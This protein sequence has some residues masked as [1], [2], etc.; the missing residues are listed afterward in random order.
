MR[1]YE[2]NR[3]NNRNNNNRGQKLYEPKQQYGQVQEQQRNLRSRELRRKQLAVQE[4]EFTRQN[5]KY[6]QVQFTTWFNQIS[7][8]VPTIHQII[9]KFQAYNNLEE[10]FTKMKIHSDQLN[11]YIYLMKIFGQ[12][13]QYDVQQYIDLI[14]S[15]QS[16]STQLNEKCTLLLLYQDSIDYMNQELDTIHQLFFNLKL[17]DYQAL[18][19][20][21]IANFLYVLKIIELYNPKLKNQVVQIIDNCDKHI[22]SIYSTNQI[23]LWRKTPIYPVE[24]EFFQQNDKPNQLF[25][26]LETLPSENISFDQYIDFHFNLLRQ[27]YI[28]ELKEAIIS[29]NESG[30]E[31]I[32]R[33][34]NNNVG[35][36]QNIELISAGMNNQDIVW[37]IQVEQFNLD[38][39]NQKKIRWEKSKKLASGSLICLT[40]IECYPLIF[41]VITQRDQIQNQY[42]NGKIQL[43]FRFLNLN[44]Q[45]MQFLNLFSQKTI[46][47]QSEGLIDP[48]L[49]YLES[50]KKKQSLPFSQIIIQN[51]N[52][53]SYP[54]YL[55]DNCIFNID[56]SYNDYYQGYK[57]NI[58]QQIWPQL[59]TTLDVSQVNAIQ[60][61]L[62]REV[63]LVQGPPG[64][65]KTYCGALAVR[66]LYENLQ[67][68]DF[69]IL[70][71]CYTNHALDQFLE[72]II[73]FVPIEY[74]ARLGGASKNP[75]LEQC[76]IRC[77]QK[78]NFEFQDF[79]KLKKKMSKIIERMLYYKY[80]IM[81]KDIQTFWPNLYEQLIFY[82]I[83]DN[84]LDKNF[85]FNQNTAE[86]LVKNWINCQKPQDDIIINGYLNGM[87]HYFTMNQIHGISQQ[88]QILQKT[89]NLKKKYHDSSD[90]EIDEYLDSDEENIYNNYSQN[91]LN[92]NSFDVE[93][94]IIEFNY[95][96]QNQNQLHYDYCSIEKIKAYVNSQKGNP[97]KLNQKDIKEILKYLQCLRYQNDS[98]KFQNQYKQFSEQSNKLKELQDENEIQILN[99]MKIV[100]VTV[101]GVAKQTKK[102][103]QLNTKIMVIEEAAEVLESHIASI[104]TSNLQHLILIGDHQQLKPTLKNYALQEKFKANVSLFE[105]LF[106][107]K[108]PSVTLSSQRRMKTKFADFIRQIYGQTYE[109]H[110][111]ILKLNE[112]EIIGLEK[113]LVFFNHNW[114]EEENENSK[115]NKQEAQMIYKMVLYLLDC[116]HQQNQITVLTLYLKQAQALKRLFVKQKSIKVQ[117]VDNYQG[118]ENDI[119]IIS[120]VRN[121]KNNN[122]GYIKI[123][124]R[125]N[126]ALSRAKIGLYVFGNFDFILKASSPGCTWQKMILLAQ[127]KNCLNDY[128]N[129]KCIPHG[130]CQ[131]IRRPEDWNKIKP[132][133][134]DKQCLKN[135]QNCNHLCDKK[136]HLN[137]SHQAI[138]CPF[139]CDRIINCGHKCRYLC[140]EKCECIEIVEFTLPCGHK[141]KDKC[142]TDLKTYKCQEKLQITF[143]KCDH[144]T[145]YTCSERLKYT[146]ECLKNCQRKLLC[147]HICNKICSQ[148]CELCE[149]ECQKQRPCGHKNKC[150]NK[151]YQI[152]T[153]CDTLVETKL[154]C[155]HQSNFA[156]YSLNKNIQNYICQQDCIKKRECGHDDQ[157]CKNKCNQLCSLCEKIITR[158][159][160]CGHDI[161]VK[162]CQSDIEVQKE[163][164]MKECQ[165][166]RDCKHDSIC[167]NKC[168]EQCSPCLKLIKKTLI[169]GHSIQIQ[170]YKSKEIYLCQDKCEK[171]RPCNHNQKCTNI[172]SKQCSPC[173]EIIKHTF[174]CGHTHEFFCHSYQSQIENFICSKSCLLQ[175]S[176]GHDSPCL[177]KCYENKCSPCQQ[178]VNKKLDC[179]HLI[180]VECFRFNKIYK[181]KQPCNKIRECGHI[182][183]CSTLCSDECQPCKLE[184][185]KNLPCGH[186]HLVKCYQYE[187]PIICKENC[188]KIRECGHLYPCTNQCNQNCTNCKQIVQL[189]LKCG[190]EIDVECSQSQFFYQNYKCQKQCIKTRVCGHNYPCFNMCFKTDECTP[191]QDK[192]FKFLDCGHQSQILCYQSILD[193]KIQ[194]DLPCNKKR[195][196][197]H[198]VACD[199]LCFQPC[200]PCTEQCEYVF[201]CGHQSSIM[202]YQKQ[203]ETFLKNFACMHP[204]NKKKICGHKTIC[205]QKCYQ[206]CDLCQNEIQLILNCG[207]LKQT[208]C[209]ENLNTLKCSQPCLIPKQ[210]GHP[211]KQICGEQCQECEENITK[212]FPSCYHQKIIKCYQKNLYMVCEE[213]VPVKYSCDKHT[214]NISCFQAQIKLKQCPECTKC[215]IF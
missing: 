180:Q 168:H 40:N 54:L 196:C 31:N 207:H 51:Q 63:A 144:K 113:D 99:S 126:V 137:D 129:T 43:E 189:N 105:R 149:Q 178:I 21:N 121:N 44:T 27:D 173:N 58:Y 148:N 38:G 17:R 36:Y 64:T 93:K 134:C 125:I 161:Q 66:I 202:C 77:R 209:S 204:C 96:N 175:R 108:I 61:M 9:Q 152:C 127:K 74:V 50:L 138:N 29:L 55:N 68:K 163:K 85:D 89:S 22:S 164:C 117:T 49:Y 24:L 91:N 210:C 97:W 39:R 146:K 33:K 7:G 13:N 60:L 19:Q 200:S 132:H 95:L 165:K 23:L 102:L 145:I 214:M 32:N 136:C 188:I 135:Y 69:P 75:I 199:K 184:L 15:S 28:V 159:L 133:L 104:L 151:C 120:L 118:E 185:F 194:C 174:P 76:Q 123:E 90:E 211:C 183:P 141:I 166:K 106:L 143:S 8:Q 62:Q 156:C 177:S 130:N 190:H 110:P 193:L 86:E 20:S 187:Q 80:K 94:A 181:C 46:L 162:C 131:I 30:F 81:P 41:G 153:P 170:C 78:V 4:R 12:Q 115:E 107:N 35:L 179:G 100:G 176:C 65:G 83:Q 157:I 119:V 150:K 18:K 114:L 16:F 171:I 195:S 48:I 103:Q 71:V 56:L 167:L 82:F 172:C 14:L 92:F 34:I 197:G 37:K 124:N 208:I 87:N 111:D 57:F 213:L 98:I 206:Q 1:R 10:L 2:E 192:I 122:L 147:G 52:V 67:K 215:N 42:K 205:T 45:L 154:I 203:D 3:N 6:N 25:G 84:N 160:K 182:F 191:C 53:V 201:K 26:K 155:G 70:I 112:K 101:T 73:K 79:N 72:H 109:D 116:G 11:S 142:G 169:C 158:Q 139:Q 212:R 59:Q 128:I 140:R 186:K 198:N 88:F 47:I 5:L